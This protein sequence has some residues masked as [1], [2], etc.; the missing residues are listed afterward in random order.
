MLGIDIPDDVNVVNTYPILAVSDNALAQAFVDE[1][2]SARG[3]QHL[4]DAGFVAP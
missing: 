1:V 4:A 3:Q 2:M